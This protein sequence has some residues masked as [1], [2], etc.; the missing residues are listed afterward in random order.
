MNHQNRNSENF[1]IRSLFLYDTEPCHRVI[2]AP[3]VHGAPN[4]RW[5]TGWYNTQWRD[6]STH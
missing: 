6:G 3:I 1:E 5:R 2:G 4:T